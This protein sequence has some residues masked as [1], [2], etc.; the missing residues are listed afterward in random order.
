[1]AVLDAPVTLTVGI[2]SEPYQ[3]ELSLSL[4]AAA[5]ERGL[6]V[7]LVLND[8]EYTEYEGVVAAGNDAPM[9]IPISSNVEGDVLC[10][11]YVDDDLYSE[12]TITL[13]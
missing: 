7:A 8:Q 9:L 3:G 1:M 10:R 13:H 12:E 5:K 6:R 11:V 2:E 4:P